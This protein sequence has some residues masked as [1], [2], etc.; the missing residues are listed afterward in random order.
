MIRE[1]VRYSVPV[2]AAVPRGNPDYRCITLRI[3]EYTIAL[4]A[5]ARRIRGA[6]RRCAWRGFPFWLPG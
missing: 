6:R 2:P 3:D 4:F 5:G 1:G